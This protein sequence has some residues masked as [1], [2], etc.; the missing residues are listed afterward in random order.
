[1]FSV[2]YGW[3]QWRGQRV[4]WLFIALGLSLLTAMTL[5]LSQLYLQLVEPKPT[6]AGAQQ[7]LVTVQRQDPRGEYKQ[8]ANA[9]LNKLNQ[10][11]AIAE[12]ARLY[13]GVLDLRIAGQGLPGSSVLYYSANLPQLLQLPAPFNLSR[14]SETA[15][16]FGVYLSHWLWQVLDKPVL[17]GLMV[18]VTNTDIDYPVLG[19]LPAA[20]NRFTDQRPAI[21]LPMSQ[22][23]LKLVHQFGEQQ[24]NKPSDK[25]IAFVENMPNAIGIAK[26]T[27]KADLAELAAQFSEMPTQWLG[28]VSMQLSEEPHQTVFLPG[29]EL[30]PE[31]RQD[32]LSQWWLLCCLT[33]LLAAVVSLNL[34]VCLFGQ[35]IRRNHEMGMRRVFGAGLAKLCRQCLLEQLPLCVLALIVGLLFYGLMVEILSSVRIFQHYFGPNGLPFNLWV[36]AGMAFATSGFI[37]LCSLMPLLLLMGKTRFFRSRQAHRNR[38]QLWLLRAQFML[39]MTFAAYALLLAGSLQI[40][41]W[42][43]QQAIEKLP[44]SEISAKFRPGFKV[45]ATL[46]QGRLGG[47]GADEIGLSLGTF[48][49][50]KATGSLAHPANI[51][52]EI[53][54]FIQSVSTNYLRLHNPQLLAG[55]YALEQGQ[56]VINQTLAR[57]LLNDGTDYQQLIGRDLTLQIP[58]PETKRVVGVV[59]DLPHKG[60]TGLQQPIVYQQMSNNPWY[61]H[62]TLSMYVRPELIDQAM[63]ELDF[64]ADQQSLD[65]EQ[66]PKGPLSKQLQQLNEPQWLFAQT[67]LVMAL[68]ISLLASLSVYYQVTAQL[69]LQQQRLGTM[70]AVGAS[71][72]GLVLQL[73][74]HHLLL[75]SLTAPLVWGLLQWLNPWLASQLGSAVFVPSVIPLVLVFLL[76]LVLLASWLPTHWLLRRP[77]SRLLQSS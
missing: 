6:W 12:N 45:D 44:L 54:A 42:Q 73:C 20:L 67:S 64:W 57:W 21:W 29:I 63:D 4:Q 31:Q 3:R 46:Q 22:N 25:T 77:I 27:G 14:N 68:L 16:Q 38:W 59:A 26:L 41:L 56:Y 76:L 47:L 8:I 40:L 49:N 19:V 71:R 43:Q 28:I 75:L 32:L 65:V 7:H 24:L 37:L 61:K 39:Q 55:E 51:D 10:M 30:F 66:L 2:I 53:E 5:L 62:T 15:E 48:T 50:V 18:K 36:W 34:M 69:A 33:I 17:D 72:G 70:L 35:F 60:V 9:E 74:G 52:H 13:F 1:M 11:P 58:Y 23:Y